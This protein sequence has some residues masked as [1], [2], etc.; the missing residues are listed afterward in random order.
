VLQQAQ[1]FGQL[2]PAE[3]AGEAER[4]DHRVGAKAAAP[5]ERGGDRDVRQVPFEVHY[6]VAPMV[7]GANS[8]SP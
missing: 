2:E 3:R 8:S 6:I 5:R 7:H 1:V 4:E